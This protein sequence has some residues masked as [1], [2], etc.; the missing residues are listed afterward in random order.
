MK[1]IFKW[2]WP[3]SASNIQ[4]AV[5]K[6][7]NYLQDNGYRTS[8]IQGYVFRVRNYLRFAGTSR[9]TQDTFNEFRQVLHSKGLKR[10]TINGY[11]ISIKAYHKMYGEEVTYKF[12]KVNDQIPY[13]FD[14]EDVTK[15]FSVIRNYKHYAMLNVLFYGA[16]RVSELC[17][18]NID[19][20]D[21]DNLTVRVREGKGGVYS[22]SLISPQCSDILKS[23]L[24]MRSPLDIDGK[25]PLFYTDYENRWQGIEVSRLFHRYKMKAGIV[26][27]GGAH[28]FARHTVASLMVKNGCDL[29]TIKEILR[30]KSIESSMR[31]LHLTDSTKRSKYDRYL[32]L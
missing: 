4:P 26:K 2:D 6:F 8:V 15:I 5:V 13:F 31:Y 16:L 23:Y 20:I 28:V 10:S 7:R 21:L 29:L 17:A 14:E 1:R 32:R 3:S 25:Q 12:L 30:H 9:P 22:I 24:E 18:L 19:D 11:S 27:P